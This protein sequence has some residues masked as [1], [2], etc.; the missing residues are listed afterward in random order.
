MT[1]SNLT[2]LTIEEQRSIDGGIVCGGLCIAGVVA[3]GLSFGIGFGVGFVNSNREQ[4]RDA[5]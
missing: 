2:V 3:L 1:F 5:E 4:Q